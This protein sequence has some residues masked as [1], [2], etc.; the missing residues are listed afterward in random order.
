MWGNR[1]C[2]SYDGRL[3]NCDHIYKNLFRDLSFFW[4]LI[5]YILFIN[6]FFFCWPHCMAQG[7]RRK[8]QPTPV[9]LPGESQGW[10]AW[11]AAVYGVAQSQTRLKQLSSSGSSMARGSLSSLTRDW[12]L[13]PYIGSLKSYL[14]DDQG[15][16]HD[17]V[18]F[19]LYEKEKVTINSYR[20]PKPDNK[21]PCYQASKKTRKRKSEITK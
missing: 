19:F 20:T 8:W 12:T 4:F 10:G 3:Y 2:F 16:P 13:G 11:W 14:L 7:W 17:H 15:S 18:F 9:F 5:I 6:F 1:W 21:W